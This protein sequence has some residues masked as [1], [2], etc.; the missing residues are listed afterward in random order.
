M[1]FKG[2]LY[3]DDYVFPFAFLLPTMI[4]GSFFI[5]PKCF[6][7]YILKAELIHNTEPKRNQFY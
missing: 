1:D 4:T 2:Q 3:Q 6:L 7:K 5:S